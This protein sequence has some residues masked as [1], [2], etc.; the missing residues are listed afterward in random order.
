MR[1]VINSSIITVHNGKRIAN[2]LEN[3]LLWEPGQRCLSCG[4]VVATT[5]ILI[6]GTRV[7][8]KPDPKP[9]SLLVS[10]WERGSMT[11]VAVGC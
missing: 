1:T 3:V 9:M 4:H 7:Q 5:H 6:L 10:E 8:D 2:R 11:L